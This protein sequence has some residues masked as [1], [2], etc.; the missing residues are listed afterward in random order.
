MNI[1]ELLIQKESENLLLGDR[2]ANERVQMTFKDVNLETDK[3]VVVQQVYDFIKFLRTKCHRSWIQDK[4]TKG[5]AKNLNAIMKCK[6]KNALSNKVY[7]FAYNISQDRY[8]YLFNSCKILAWN[9]VIK[10]FQEQDIIEK[11]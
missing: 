11:R 4:L 5:E 8:D 2:W 6:S 10:N 3:R 7:T 9:D 1:D